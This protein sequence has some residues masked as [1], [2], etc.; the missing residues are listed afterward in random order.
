MTKSS[1][2]TTAAAAAL[3]IAALLSG[4]ALGLGSTPAAAQVNCRA[5][6]THAG[7]VRCLRRQQ[8]IYREQSQ[9]Y[10]DI[11]RQLGRVERGARY[12]DYGMRA[13][14]WAVQRGTRGRV[15]AYDAYR[16]GRAI[17]NAMTYGW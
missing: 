8:E 6:S 4:A 12:F 2:T 7:Y 10:G 3:A 1:K 16:A 9:A 13:G 5:A 15:R 14:T 11:N 17:G